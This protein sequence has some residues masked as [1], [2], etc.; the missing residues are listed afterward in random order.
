MRQ[1]LS[2]H[3]VGESTSHCTLLVRG[4]NVASNGFLQ[5]GLFINICH[6]EGGRGFIT[7]QCDD[8]YISM[9]HRMTRGGGGGGGGRAFIMVKNKR[10][11]IY[12]RPPLWHHQRL[13]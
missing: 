1:Y 5:L 3:G 2:F 10:D 7:S 11:V 12:E 4:A 6:T 8:A 13:T 9:G